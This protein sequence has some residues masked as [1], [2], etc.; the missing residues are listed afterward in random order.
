MHTWSCPDC[1]CELHRSG[2]TLACPQCRRRWREQNLCASCAGELELLQAC[3]AIDYFC[4][5]CRSL[6][7]KSTLLRSLVP[8]TPQASKA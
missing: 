6:Q 2:L 3:G 8:D 4:P 5:R 1:R 7:S